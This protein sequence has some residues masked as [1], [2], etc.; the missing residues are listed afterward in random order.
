[1]K[2][3]VHFLFFFL[4][5]AVF[6]ATA[7][8]AAPF[9]TEN[10]TAGIPAGWGNADGSGQNILWGWCANPTSGNSDPGCPAIFDDAINSQIPFQA[11]TASTGFVSLD[12]DE[13]QQLPN[14]HICRLTTTPINCSGKNEVFITFQ[15]HIGVYDV[16]AEGGAILRVST[17]QNTWTDYTVFPGL[18]TTERWSDN[19]EFPIID[20][21]ATAA[22]QA[23]VYIQWQWTG[24]WE[25]QWSIDDI[26]IYGQNPTPRHDL[27][28]R[29]VFYPASSFTTPASQIATDTFGFSVNIDNK[30]LEAQTNI[31]V[32]VT[33]TDTNDVPYYT[34]SLNI[35][36]IAEGV[37]DEFYA[38]TGQFIPVL[39]VGVYLITY[40]MF[41]DSVDLRPS[42]NTITMPFVIS[43]SVFAKE[44]EPEQAYR[45]SGGGDWAVANYYR[46]ATGLQEQYN[47]IDAEFAFT[48]NEDEVPIVDVE[49]GILLF[50]LNDDVAE[51]F[52]NFDDSALFTG[53][54]E[55]IGVGNYEAP[56]TV[57]GYQL[58]TSPILDANTGEP[59]L[60][61]VS[62]GRYLLAVQYS[63]ASSNAFHAFNDDIT[64]SF[65]STLVN[66]DDWSLGGF[67][68]N[69]N[70]VL[71]MRIGLAS[72]TDEVPL[73]DYA[74]QCSPNPTTDAIQ[75]HLNFE[76]P[77]KATITIAQLD[78]RVISFEDR[79]G[80]TNQTLRY[81]ANHLSAGTYLVRIA[82]P[83]GTLT[84]KVIVQH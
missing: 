77:T 76:Q 23:T 34:K 46:M 66:T 70:A 82:T 40:T 83:Q 47:V 41:A 54:A 62:G 15:T 84:K 24:N 10:F 60:P 67:G 49:A 2:K 11:T 64:T 21:S 1:M 58:Q 37:E 50:K 9:W 81:P 52:S 55:W 33:V 61:L 74:M 36:S 63:G 45:P 19:P 71:R 51:D 6:H 3:Q 16:D 75:L 25:Y 4:L 80:L 72:T 42:N 8:L 5:F 17:D 56:D 48:T 79:E 12:S 20:I 30:G 14:N 32:Q 78:G 53:S 59:G 65:V 73:P 38:F 28:F 13:P 26:E 69:V 39:P 68:S 22:N 31:Q 35:P 27:A 18:T 29:S 43:E 7:Q 57:Q 44:D